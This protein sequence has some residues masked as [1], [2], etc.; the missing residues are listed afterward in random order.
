[1]PTRLEREA[2]RVRD[3]L[4]KGDPAWPA[5]LAVALTIVLYFALPGK[6]TLGPNWLIPVAEGV[7]LVGL[8]AATPRGPARH[9]Q[10]RRRLA[11]GLVALVSFANLV[12]LIL[13]IH[14]LLKGGKAS[15]HPLI[16]AGIELWVTN[17]L[18]FGVWFWELDRGGP[19][20]RQLE[21]EARLPD[22]LFPQM[23]QGGISPPGWRPVFL[24]Y[25][26][27]SFTNATAFSPTDTMPLSRWAKMLMLVE[28]AVSLV[29][30]IMVAARAINILK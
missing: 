7:L 9:S 15:G 1:M 3:R 24:D 14:Y 11:M 21:P 27:T 29:L 10:P 18:L 25:L 2:A 13:L 20:S 5:Q 26:Y 8:V 16:L 19:V 22:F 4:E 6:L 12:S 30:A 28:S 23:T 17:V